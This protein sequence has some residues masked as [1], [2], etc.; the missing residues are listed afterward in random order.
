M[1]QNNNI[2]PNSSTNNSPSEIPLSATTSV[3]LITSTSTD[4]VSTSTVPDSISTDTV[5]D[6]VVGDPVLEEAPTPE[7]VPT[8]TEPSTDETLNTEQ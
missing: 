2:T 4:S 3:E 7:P 1:L 8:P 5:P 6:A